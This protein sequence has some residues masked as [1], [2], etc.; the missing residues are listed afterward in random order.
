M[1]TLL[2]LVK[3]KG[4]HIADIDDFRAELV[5][6]GD[7]MEG[8]GALK[9]LSARDW[10][11]HSIKISN[12]RICPSEH[13]V[14]S[15]FVCFRVSDNRLVG[16]IKLR[17]YLNDFLEKY[18]GHIGYSVRPSE[19]GKG[20]GTWMLKS[21]LPF[22]KEIGLEQVLVCCEIGNVASRKTILSAGGVFEKEDYSPNEDIYLERY[23]IKT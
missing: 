23:W 15:Q 12:P 21:L 3:L 4:T 17:H 1:D 13:V 6:T 11:E 20:Y 5:A 16:I 14:T 10:V 22:C 8:C 2:I 7:A 18:V 9:D 19:R